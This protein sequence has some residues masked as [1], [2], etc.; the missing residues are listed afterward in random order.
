MAINMYSGST[1]SREGFF[2]T[3][4]VITAREKCTF[5]IT[6][7]EM[8]YLTEAVSTCCKYFITDIVPFYRPGHMQ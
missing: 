1:I 5:V 3:Y 4:E 2:A 6:V 7:K 8:R